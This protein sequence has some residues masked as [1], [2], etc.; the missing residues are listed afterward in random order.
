LY[1]YKIKDDEWNDFYSPQGIR[2][3]VPVGENIGVLVHDDEVEMI[4]F[5]KNGW[6]KQIRDQ[7][8]YDVLAKNN[9]QM[10]AVEML[11]DDSIPLKIITGVEGTGKRR[12]NNLVL[13]RPTDEVGKSLGYL[14]G[15]LDDKFGAH[16]TAFDMAFTALGIE[17]FDRDVQKPL[18]MQ[19]IQFMRG[20]SYPPGTIVWADE[21]AGMSPHE[22][23]MLCTRL[24]KDCLLV[25][26]GSLEQI[27][28]KVQRTETGLYKLLNSKKI[29]G[30]KLVGHIELIENER[31]E[32]SKLISEVL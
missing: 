23:R 22:L 18:T 14:P 21:I 3:A 17:D 20:I 5:Y 7:A 2:A 24:G 6:I 4:G 31:S 10:V 16:I 26:T 1:R 25:L 11:M 19:P 28:R 29:Q 27:D 32:L 15:S 30:S 9:E 13:T 12:Y 8:V